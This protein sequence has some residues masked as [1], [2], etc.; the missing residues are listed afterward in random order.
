MSKRKS[1]SGTDAAAVLRRRDIDPDE[2]LSYLTKEAMRAYG[3]CLQ[4][5]LIDHSVSIG[6]WLFLR[7][8]WSKDGLGQ[9]ELSD[10]VGLMESTTFTAL[11]ALES[12]GYVTRRNRP[13]NK[14]KIY[15]YLTP[16]GRRLRAVLTP[17]ATELNNKSLRGIKPADVEITRRTLVAIIRNLIQDEADLLEDKRRV[18]STRDLSQLI[19]RSG[20]QAPISRQVRRP[21]GR[22]SPNGG[23]AL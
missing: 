14:K 12:L 18:P 2:K 6:H 16:K 1:R 9:R 17:V 10:Y 15:V 4:I 20:A 22:H 3:R 23:R 21:P 7:A 5:R 19:S 11:G 13:G 8:L